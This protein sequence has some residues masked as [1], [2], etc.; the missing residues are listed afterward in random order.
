[1]IPLQTSV[2]HGDRR[3]GAVDPLRMQRVDAD[4]IARRNHAALRKGLDRRL[5]A[6]D[7]VDRLNPVE[8]RNCVCVSRRRFNRHGIENAAVCIDRFGAVRG[9]LHRVQRPACRLRLCRYAVLSDVAVKLH[10]QHRFFR[11]SNLRCESRPA[12]R[13][14]AHAQNDCQTYEY[15]F[16]HKAIS[17][18]L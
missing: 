18:N 14:G 10:N 2:D 17:P 4:H 9:F 6:A 8:L 5:D 7:V 1:M 3:T 12:D 13:T 15:Y 11:T 16:S